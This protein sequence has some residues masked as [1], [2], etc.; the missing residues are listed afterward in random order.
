MKSSPLVSVIIPVYNEEQYLSYCL[1]SLSNQSYS[2]FEILVVD[3]GSTD[4]SLEI[5][6]KY[7]VIILQQDHKGP[8][9][10]RNL[11][12]KKAL[13]KILVFADADMRY[14]KK[15]IEMLIRPIIEKNAVGT[16]VKEEMVANTDNIWSRCWSYNSGLPID[17]R[18]PINYKDTENAFRA[19]LKE[20]FVKAGGFDESVGYTDDSSISKKLHIFAVNASGAKSY[21]YNPSSLSEVFISSRWIGRSELFPKSIVNFLRFSPLNS[22][23]VASKLLLKGTPFEIFIFKLVYDMGVFTGIFL[24]KNKTAK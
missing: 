3:D 6:K 14:D 1:S 15:Y 10:A 17:R 16:F 23:R 8:G 20:Y 9:A 12:A 4:K 7:N 2:S 21:H 24:S 11:G 22:I 19:I 13:G 18:L 5:A